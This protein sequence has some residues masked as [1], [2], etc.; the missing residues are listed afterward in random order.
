MAK[1]RIKRTRN[2]SLSSESML[3]AALIISSVKNGSSTT[4][5][6]IRGSTSTSKEMAAEY[7]FAMGCTISTEK[8][9]YSLLDDQ[10]DAENI[11]NENIDQS[12]KFSKLKAGET[13]ATDK[14]A[15]TSDPFYEL[16]D[17]LPERTKAVKSSIAAASEPDLT[18]LATSL[19]S[20]Q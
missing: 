19:V 1:K 3:E 16:D 17:D 4:V 8:I 13:S 15:N 7:I 20:M 12:K 2:N 14:F 5:S 9:E 18:T 10:T 6:S 11:E